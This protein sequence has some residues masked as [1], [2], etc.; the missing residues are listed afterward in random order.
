MRKVC[1]LIMLCMCTVMARPNDTTQTKH[2]YFFGVE[3]KG[4]TSDF[5]EK[6]AQQENIEMRPEH[7]T[8]SK[9]V[10]WH[11][12]AENLTQTIITYGMLYEPYTIYEVEVLF[13]LPKDTRWESIKY[14]YDAL[15]K[16]YATLGKT[17]EDRIT[18]EP[19]YSETNY[20]NDAVLNDKATIYTTYEMEGGTVKIEICHLQ[21][22]LLIKQTFVDAIGDN[23]N[24]R[25]ILNIALPY[26]R[27]V[28]L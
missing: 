7:C 10:F 3:M 5:N 24:T 27:Q 20:P 8:R 26:G 28:H 18:F 12:I 25:Y 9:G 2:L 6:L 15:K 21:D 13:N 19:P 14:V 16:T 4:S 23:E 11:H 22:L 17:I 1:F